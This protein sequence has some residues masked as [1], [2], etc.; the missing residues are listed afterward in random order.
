MT[1]AANGRRKA[2]GRNRAVCPEG[3]LEIVLKDLPCLMEPFWVD[4]GKHTPR[5]RSALKTEL[6]LYTKVK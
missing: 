1:A 3:A 2:A 6:A 5:I 4:P